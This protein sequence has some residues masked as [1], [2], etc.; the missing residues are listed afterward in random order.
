M[1]AVWRAA[2]L[3]ALL[4]VLCGGCTLVSV[5]APGGENVVARGV[6]RRDRALLRRVT[7][8]LLVN[9]IELGKVAIFVV[10]TE[11]PPAAAATGAEQ[12]QRQQQQQQE[13]EE[14]GADAV[15]Y[16][17]RWDSHEDS[18]VM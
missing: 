12:R 16:S 5:R 9:Q 2:P 11:A 10:P 6:R 17:W 14:T 4:G 3:V 13:Q 7:G 15:P 8:Y 1:C 18:E